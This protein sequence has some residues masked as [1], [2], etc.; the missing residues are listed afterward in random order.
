MSQ[1]LCESWCVMCWSFHYWKR[2]TLPPKT[3]HNPHRRRPQMRVNKWIEFQSS[4]TKV[5]VCWQEDP[6]KPNNWEL[7]IMIP[8]SQFWRKQWESEVS[9]EIN[10]LTFLVTTNSSEIVF[11]K[12]PCRSLHDASLISARRMRTRRSK[13]N[14]FSSVIRRRC[15]HF[16]SYYSRCELS[17]LWY[18]V[19]PESFFRKFTRRINPTEMRR[20]FN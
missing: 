16:H 8:I 12:T 2:Q 20:F 13:Q 3:T 18:C 11:I 4:H 10:I 1:I 14:I 19:A 15:D 7:M 9:T 17:S 5:W 6:R